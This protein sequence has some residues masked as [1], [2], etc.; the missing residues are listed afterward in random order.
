MKAGQ[1]AAMYGV[2]E[3]VVRCSSS[4]EDYS[5]NILPRST[6]PPSTAL[7]DGTARRDL[8][9]TSDTAWRLASAIVLLDRNEYSYPFVG[10]FAG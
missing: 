5:Y 8:V 4:A 3:I 1:I 2:V 7:L 9:R 6:L 10:T